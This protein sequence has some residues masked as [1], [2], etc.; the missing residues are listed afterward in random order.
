MISIAIAFFRLS[1]ILFQYQ[2]NPKSN[3]KAGRI[4]YSIKNMTGTAHHRRHI[5]LSKG[6]EKQCKYMYEVEKVMLYLTK[7]NLFQTL[8]LVEQKYQLSCRI[9]HFIIS[10]KIFSDVT[11]IRIITNFTNQYLIELKILCMKLIYPN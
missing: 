8:W 7:K 1:K 6:L 2:F 10:S 4:Y 9:T 11:F 5:Y 3:M